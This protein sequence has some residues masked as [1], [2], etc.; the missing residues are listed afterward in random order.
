MLV[1]DQMAGVCTREQ[2]CGLKEESFIYLQFSICEEGH[3]FVEGP[4]HCSLGV[5]S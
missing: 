2:A 4:R 3:R 1:K 5:I